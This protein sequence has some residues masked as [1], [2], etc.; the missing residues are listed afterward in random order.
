MSFVA[1]LGCEVRGDGPVSGMAIL[2]A[3]SAKPA[4]VE[5]GLHPPAAVVR[6]LTRAVEAEIAVVATVLREPVEVR[7]LLEPK[8]DIE[9]DRVSL[10]DTGAEEVEAFS[11]KT[12][13]ASPGDASCPNAVIMA[14]RE[15]QFTG[16]RDPAE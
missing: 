6:E 8:P 1:L 16:V 4:L 9:R 12:L 14:S 10:I 3:P 2:D 5:P 7:R 11:W 15:D 13:R